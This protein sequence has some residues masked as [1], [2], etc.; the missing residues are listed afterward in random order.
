MTRW[1]KEEGARRVKTVEFW[2]RRKYNLP[3]SDPRFLEVTAEE[4]LA[5]YYAHLFHDN[6]KELETVE[7]DDFDPD[8][9]AEE[10]GFGS[11]ESDPDDWEELK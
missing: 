2:Y 9:V 5:D 7:D 4:M 8:K 11:G 10:I 6:P 3:A 1:A